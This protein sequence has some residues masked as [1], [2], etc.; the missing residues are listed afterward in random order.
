MDNKSTKLSTRVDNPYIWLWICGY[1]ETIHT[2]WISAC[3][4]CGYVDN[5]SVL[6]VIGAVIALLAPAWVWI[7][8]VYLLDRRFPVDKHG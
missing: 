3:G 5:R 7:T 1:P 8:C 6:V 4:L 2:L